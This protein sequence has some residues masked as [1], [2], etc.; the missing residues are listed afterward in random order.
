[1]KMLQTVNIIEEYDGKI[2]RVASF[3]DNEEGREAGDKVFKTWC[4]NNPCATSPY[5]MEEAIKN[6]CWESD[7]WRI[8][9]VYS[10]ETRLEGHCECGAEME[11]SESCGVKVCPD[12]GQHE[13]IVRCFCGWSQSGGDGRREL[14]EMG[15]NVDEDY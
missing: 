13:G 12:C 7:A 4:A 1:M 6:G 5:H 15:E 10:S 9:I 3:P 11:K 2:L 14:E 8:S